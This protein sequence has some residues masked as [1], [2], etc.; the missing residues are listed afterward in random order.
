MIG[1]YFKYASAVSKTRFL[2]G[3][4][5]SKN[6]Y[7]EIVE[8][9][10]VHDVASYLKNNT[11]YGDVLANVNENIIRRGELEKLL[12]ASVQNDYEK[13]LRFLRGKAKKFLETLFLRYEIEDLKIILRIL[14]TDQSNQLEFEYLVFLTKYSELDRDKLLLSKNITEFI[15]NLR[16]TDYYHVLAPFITSEERQNL[17][18]IEV[19]LDIHFFKMVTNAKDK[20]LSGKDKKIVSDM[21]GLEIDV[22]NIFWIYRCIKFFNMPREVILNHV[23]PHWHH[24]S[25]KQLIDLASSKNINE[26][27]DIVSKTRYIRILKSIDGPTWEINYMRFL[28]KSYR[29]HLY[30]GNYSFG[31]FIAYLRL[32]EMDIKNIVTIIE[33]IKYGLPKE[34]IKKLVVVHWDEV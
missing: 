12:K 23:I 20:F 30:S 16:D 32:K 25:R 27:K 1:P 18:N 19:S 28:D 4:L 9:K 14:S 10:S 33:G 7:N 3:K 24:L 22:L 11:G 15:E 6:H 8:K 29:K 13:L 26:F 17:F 34:E 5:L 2:H 31:T 21:S